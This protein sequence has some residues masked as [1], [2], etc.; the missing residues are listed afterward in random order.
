MGCT[1][2][3][4]T[5]SS[6]ASLCHLHARI[7]SA[8]HGPCAESPDQQESY[9]S[10]EDVL[11]SGSA[12]KTVAAPDWSST[13]GTKAELERAAKH[14]IDSFTAY[15]SSSAS[16][17]G[18]SAAEEEES[19]Y[20][21]R[22]PGSADE[23]EPDSGSQSLRLS[24]VDAFQLWNKKPSGCKVTCNGGSL[25]LRGWWP[26]RYSLQHPLRTAASLTL[27]CKSKR[28]GAAIFGLCNR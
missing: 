14:F 19:I 9:L 1:I 15:G 8:R 23:E 22:D 5:I 26:C 10:C 13:D 21:G 4:L 27:Y 17:D 3:V 25:P 6:W 24:A 28:S 11:V 16:M 18:S 12:T 20:E 7:P 2:V